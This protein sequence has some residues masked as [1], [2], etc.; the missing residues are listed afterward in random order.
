MPVY[1]LQSIAGAAIKIGFTGM[2]QRRLRRLQLSSP[3]RLC[4]LK[5]T[6]GGRPRER[7]IHERFTDLRLHGE[8]FS[9][10]PT[11][12][13]FIER[14]SEIIPLLE[15]LDDGSKVEYWRHIQDCTLVEAVQHL[16]YWNRQGRIADRRFHYYLNEFGKTLDRQEIQQRLAF[17]I[18]ADPDASPVET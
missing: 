11:L 4:L 16:E 12:L 1:F 7:E 13:D 18:P 15:V 9:P 14:L 10:D 2:F 17:D 8:W 5:L 3:D 6:P